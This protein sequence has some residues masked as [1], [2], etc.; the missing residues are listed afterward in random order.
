[1]VVPGLVSVSFR[2]LSPKRIVA[3]CQRTGL[4]AVEW[5]GDVHVPPTDPARADEV[6]KMCRAAG[7]Q[8]AAYGS[9][10]RAGQPEDAFEAVL[11][12]ALRLE[13]PIIRIWAGEC[14]S[15]A[16]DEEQ[17][18]RVVDSLMRCAQKA[19]ARGLKIALEYHGGTLTDRRESVRRLLAETRQA[20]NLTFYWQPRWDWGPQER[21]G[22]MGDLGNRLSHVH[23]FTWLHQN[24]QVIRQPLEAGEDMWL[25]VLDELRGRAEER[26]ALLEF[27]E[28]DDPA[29]LERDARTLLK[30]L[31]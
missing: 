2:A 27:V 4:R 19:G 14:G 12:A 31:R 24:S 30:W 18:A 25:Q 6:Y 16:C 26:C 7:L 1:M 21:L 22:S 29:A 17:R 23:V 11:E 5:G 20:E 28:N 8:V 10:Y 3:L 13:A 9:Y 15:E